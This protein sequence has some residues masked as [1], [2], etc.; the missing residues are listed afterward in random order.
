MGDTL[1]RHC[2]LLALKRRAGWAERI[3]GIGKEQRKISGT[4]QNRAKVVDSVLG[5]TSVVAGC[6]HNLA[7]RGNL[8]MRGSRS[9]GAKNNDPLEVFVFIDL[10]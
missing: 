9:F 2:P 7:L 8:S 5:Y 6:R 4:F 10:F 3:L 1:R